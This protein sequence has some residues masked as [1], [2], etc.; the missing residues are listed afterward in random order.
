MSLLG[1]LQLCAGTL[2]AAPDPTVHHRF[3]KRSPEYLETREFSGFEKIFLSVSINPAPTGENLV[4]V[5]WYSPQGEIKEENSLWL[6]GDGQTAKQIEFWLRLHKAST[7][8]RLIFDETFD[9]ELMGR[10]Q[11]VVRLNE[12]VLIQDYFDV[13]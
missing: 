4:T 8:K 13:G 11:V 1:W 12:T 3:F 10:W 5:E 9:P 2:L 7:I 6:T